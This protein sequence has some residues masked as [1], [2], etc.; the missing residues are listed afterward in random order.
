MKK[1]YINITT[2]LLGLCLATGAAIGQSEDKPA[3]SKEVVIITKTVDDEGNEKMIKKVYKDGE[4]SDEELDKLIEAETGAE[5]DVNIW[6][7]DKGEEIEI[8]IDDTKRMAF[9]GED[10]ID[11]ILKDLNLTEDD[12]KEM[13][14]NAESEVV[15]GK[16][17]MKQT[18]TIVDKTGKQYNIEKKKEITAADSH[19]VIMKHELKPKLGVMVEETE[20]GQVVVDDIVPGS[21]AESAGLQKGDHI[22]AVGGTAVSNM[23][24]LLAALES[25]GDK[26]TISYTRAGQAATAAVTFSDFKYEGGAKKK[27]RKRMIIKED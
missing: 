20:A 13:N 21:P 15:D 27:I 23:T 16:E 26:T 18:I 11:Q 12:V 2:I 4:L 25:A 22:T 1:Q 14:I 7:S 24:E 19:T 17:I 6:K 8:T 9:V 10:E 5:V 3:S